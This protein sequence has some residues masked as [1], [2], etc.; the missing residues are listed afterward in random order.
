MMRIKILS[1]LSFFCLITSTLYGQYL[2]DTQIGEAMGIYD[3]DKWDGYDSLYVMDYSEE[4]TLRAISTYKNNRFGII[5]KDIE[6]DL[7]RLVFSPVAPYS[8]GVGLNHNWLG[9]NL[10]L[11][12]PLGPQEKNETFSQIDLIGRYYTKAIG[13]EGRAQYFQGHYA[14]VRPIQGAPINLDNAPKLNTML[15]SVNATYV[16]NQKTYSYMANS[17]QTQWQKK[18]AGSWLLGGFSTFQ[19]Y[20]N[21]KDNTLLDKRKLNLDQSQYFTLGLTGGY[22][23]TWVYKSH[24]FAGFSAMAGVGGNY[25]NLQTLAKNQNDEVMYKPSIMTVSRLFVGY[26]NADFFVVINATTEANYIFINSYSSNM[27][28]GYVRLSVGKRFAWKAK[29]KVLHEIGLD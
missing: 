29:N 20:W 24:W 16:F 10:S 5:S 13:F 12:M 18:S 1:L 15:V 26:N 23:Y 22:G 14:D 17:A 21:H 3:H 6:G 27:I 28:Q 7:H 11:T 4:W 25:I 19:H 9:V 2:K 8:I